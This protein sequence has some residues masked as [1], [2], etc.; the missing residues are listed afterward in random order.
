[1]L[2][3]PTATEAENEAVERK[4][5]QSHTVH[6]SKIETWLR[7]LK[8][9]HPAYAD[10]EIDEEALRS[11]PEGESVHD[12]FVSRI[13]VSTSDTER[14]PGSSNEDPTESDGAPT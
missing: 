3:P 12:Q 11:L 8:D 10:V 7:Y 6:H 9:N 1:L 4:F 13:E 5:N 2:K 14:E